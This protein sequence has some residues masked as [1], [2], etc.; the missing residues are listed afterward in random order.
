MLEFV[1]VAPRSVRSFACRVRERDRCFPVIALC[2]REI[3]ARGTGA[4]RGGADARTTA[5]DAALP[6]KDR[7]SPDEAGILVVGDLGR[8]ATDL[9]DAPFPTP[10]L[11]RGPLFSEGGGGRSRLLFIKDASR[12]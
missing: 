8:L 6:C 9:S 3:L 12:V 7:D 1:Q 10:R 5:I 2:E 4:V 11:R